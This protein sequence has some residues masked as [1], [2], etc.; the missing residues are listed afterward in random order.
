M[1]KQIPVPGSITLSLAMSAILRTVSTPDNPFTHGFALNV[2]AFWVGHPE[3]EIIDSEVEE[4]LI[5]AI[6]SCLND[7]ERLALSYIHKLGVT[8]YRPLLD[9]PWKSGKL[10]QR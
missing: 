8:K 2:F 5:T 4:L 6:P 1:S 10:S 3:A 7:N 9:F